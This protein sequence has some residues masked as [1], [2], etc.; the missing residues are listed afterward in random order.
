MNELP[1]DELTALQ[2]S[3][4]CVRCGHRELFHAVF[5][6]DGSDCSICGWRGCR[7]FLREW[8]PLDFEAAWTEAYRPKS[9]LELMY[10]NMLMEVLTN[11]IAPPIADPG[12]D[13]VIRF[14]TAAELTGDD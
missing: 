9:G 13:K 10:Q 14:T 3:P 7:D 1:A 4:K 8:R 6:D 5:S 11:A 12:T 2:A